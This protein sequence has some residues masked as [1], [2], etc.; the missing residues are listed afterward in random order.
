[1]P[2][3]SKA[4][5][6]AALDGLRGYAA[7]SV[8]FYHAVLHADASLIDR[9]LYVPIQSLGNAR[10]ILAK[11]VLTFLNGGLAVYVFFVLSGCVLAGSLDRK[12]GQAM[13]LALRFLINR[14]GRLY[15][16]VIACMTIFFLMGYL[17]IPGYPV[18]HFEQF[19][20]NALLV[21]I[22]MH[23]PSGTVQGELLGAPFVF[24]AWLIKDKFGVAGLACVVA[25]AVLALES[26]ALVFW[27]PSMHGYLLAFIAGVVASELMKSRLLAEPNRNRFG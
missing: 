26:A 14:C 20:L 16:P 7:L 21:K 3:I 27:L 24:A 22:S 5:R 13:S 11:L 8:V 6:Y 18:F 17:H 25:Y 19:W 4:P 10:D 23:G 15:P 1:M 9:V 2:T 12:R